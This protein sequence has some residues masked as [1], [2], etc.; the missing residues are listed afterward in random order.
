M[1]GQLKRS[2]D[3]LDKEEAKFISVVYDIKEDGNFND[4]YSQTSSNNILHM[5]HDIDELKDILNLSR[6]GY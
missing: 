5:K 1:Y 2:N 6:S 4:G 3:I